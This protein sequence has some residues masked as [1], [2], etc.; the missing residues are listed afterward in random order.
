[1]ILAF[2]VIKNP[3]IKKFL[4]IPIIPVTPPPPGSSTGPKPGFSFFEALNKF[5]AAK[6]KEFLQ[7]KEALQ[8]KQSLQQQQP[9]P[10]SFEETP[11]PTNPR[12]APSTS[13][14]ALNHRIKTLEKEV[15]GRKKGKKR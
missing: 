8:Q 15:K 10:S 1:M 12:I 13:S 11:K 9:L 7:Q 4:G 2:S 6:Q 14:P 5:M 3:E